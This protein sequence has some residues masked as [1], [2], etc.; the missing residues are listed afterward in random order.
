MSN[1]IN[2]DLVNK[3]NNYMASGMQLFGQSVT[4]RKY[5]SAS[6]GNPDAGISD[7]LCYQNRPTMAELRMLSI[8]E[9]QAVGGQDIRGTYEVVILDDVGMRDEILYNGET[10]RWMSQPEQE[11]IGSRLF[12]KGLIQ[13]ASI[14]GYYQ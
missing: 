2:P 7:K 8:V 13:R 9:A 11:V 3:L 14:T 6:A 4:W 10:Y 12:S 1:R 5:I